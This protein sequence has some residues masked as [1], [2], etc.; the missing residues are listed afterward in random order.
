[1][2]QLYLSSITFFSRFSITFFIIADLLFISL[3]F[4]YIRRIFYCNLNFSNNNYNKKKRQNFNNNELIID[5]QSIFI[6]FK[7]LKVLKFQLLFVEE[8]RFN[9][10]FLFIETNYRILN[11]SSSFSS[12]KI[13]YLIIFDLWTSFNLFI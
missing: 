8:G 4:N 1:L 2:N 10:I 5:C 11:S 6:S 13:L 12:K 7:R 9:N 3:Y